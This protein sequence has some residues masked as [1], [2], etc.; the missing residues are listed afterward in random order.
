[1]FST[2]CVYIYIY[3]FVIAVVLVE[4]TWSK[5]SSLKLRTDKTS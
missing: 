2:F 5:W 1:M 3:F 4:E